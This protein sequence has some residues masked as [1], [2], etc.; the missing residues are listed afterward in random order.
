MKP[1]YYNPAGTTDV[2]VVSEHRGSIPLKH[3]VQHSPTGMTWGYYG[4]GPHDLALSILADYFEHV[5]GLNAKVALAKAGW[6]HHQFAIEFTGL[7]K[8]GWEVGSTEITAWVATKPET[9][10]VA[11]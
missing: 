4:S 5:K 3:I 7:F 8:D 9:I 10:E 6:L 1:I 2:R 11:R